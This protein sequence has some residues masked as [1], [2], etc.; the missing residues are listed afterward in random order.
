[1]P[2]TPAPIIINMPST[3]AE[4]WAPY[5][6]AGMFVIIGAVIGLL[7]TKL[8][9]KRKH[10]AD[11]RRQWDKD[12]R[13]TYS[14]AVGSSRIFSSLHL[15]KVS[16]TSGMRNLADRMI[17]ELD[18]ARRRNALLAPIVSDEYSESL[19]NLHNIMLGCLRRC[20]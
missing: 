12:I 9:D 8:S 13:E 3:G 14:E 7:S 11:D 2:P 15:V 6:L 1:M 19:A 5:A 10:A 20:S 16:D 18:N 4:W 17:N